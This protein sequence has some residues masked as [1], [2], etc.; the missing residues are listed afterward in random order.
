MNQ[1][2]RGE[3]N[4]LTGWAIAHPVKDCAPKV[5][6]PVNECAPK[7]L[8]KKIYIYGPYQIIKEIVY[9]YLPK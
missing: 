9:E 2:Y 5:A 7:V 6:H 3:N 4:M 1:L 8:G